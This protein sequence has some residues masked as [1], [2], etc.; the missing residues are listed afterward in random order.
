MIGFSAAF[1]VT[2]TSPVVHVNLVNRSQITLFSFVVGNVLV[3]SNLVCL[4]ETSVHILQF[5]EVVFCASV[6]TAQQPKVHRYNR[7]GATPDRFLIGVV[8]FSP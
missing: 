1:S 7:L 6:A 4:R 5:T 3:D 8:V 2:P